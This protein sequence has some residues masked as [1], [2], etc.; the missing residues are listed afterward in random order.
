[1][2]G[3]VAWGVEDGFVVA[4][5]EGEDNCEEDGDLEEKEGEVLGEGEVRV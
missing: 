1:V 3:G 2:V 4:D 5:A